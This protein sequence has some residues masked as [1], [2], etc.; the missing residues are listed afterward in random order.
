MNCF[1]IHIQPFTNDSISRNNQL[2]GFQKFTNGYEGM[3]MSGTKFLMEWQV[4]DKII[5]WTCFP[6]HI[7]P[8]TW[9]TQTQEI[10]NCRVSKIHE[11]IWGDVMC[12]SG[13]K[14]LME[15]QVTDKIIKW[16]VFQFTF[17]L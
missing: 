11:W 13:E 17:N 10:I 14:F 4:T 6:I 12:M 15:W 8:F 5:E 7:Q 1:P 2:W 9:M 16:I 3:Y